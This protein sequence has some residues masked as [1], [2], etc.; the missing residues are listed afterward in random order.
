MKDGETVDG[1]YSGISAELDKIGVDY[2][3][4]VRTTC[5][6]KG[7]YTV[8]H[9]QYED[10][11]ERIAYY[12]G[13]NL[14][15]TWGI[16]SEGDE[17]SGSAYT[18]AEGCWMHEEN[19]VKTRTYYYGNSDEVKRKEYSYTDNRGRIVNLYF[20]NT[21]DGRTIVT[22]MVDGEVIEQYYADGSFEEAEAAAF[23][24]VSLVH[25]PI[26]V[27]PSAL[28]GEVIKFSGAATGLLDNENFSAVLADNVID[29]VA[30]NSSYVGVAY[31]N[32]CNLVTLSSSASESFG[33]L[34]GKFEGIKDGNAMYYEIRRSQLI[35][36][37][38]IDTKMSDL[39]SEFAA[40]V[41]KVYIA[42]HGNVDAFDS[43]EDTC[44]EITI[45][46]EAYT[47][48]NNVPIEFHSYADFLEHSNKI[49][50]SNDNNPNNSSF[51]DILLYDTQNANVLA[52]SS[53]VKTTGRVNGA[54]T[55]FTNEVH[56]T[57]STSGVDFSFFDLNGLKNKIKF[58]EGDEITLD[59]LFGAILDEK[60]F[61]IEVSGEYHY[62]TDKSTVETY[63]ESLSKINE[64]QISKSFV[65]LKGTGTFELSA[66]KVKFSGEVTFDLMDVNYKYLN[67]TDYSSINNVELDLKL[68]DL[69][70]KGE[71]EYALPVGKIIDEFGGAIKKGLKADYDRLGVMKE[72]FRDIDW[73]SFFTTEPEMFY[74]PETER[75]E[76]KESDESPVTCSFEWWVKAFNLTAKIG[77]D[78]WIFD[79]NAE[80][81]L[82]WGASGKFETGEDYTRRGTD[83]DG[84]LSLLNGKVGWIVDGKVELSVRSSDIYHNDFEKAHMK[85]GYPD[86]DLMEYCHSKGLI[87]D[88]QYDYAKSVIA[89]HEAVDK[90]KADYQALA[91]ELDKQYPLG[92]DGITRPPEYYAALAEAE[93]N[94]DRWLEIME[95]QI[96]QAGLD[97]YK[98]DNLLLPGEY[99]PI[100]ERNNSKLAELHWSSEEPRFYGSEAEQLEGGSN[101]NNHPTDGQG[102]VIPSNETP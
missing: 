65:D 8:Y 81:A 63:D 6:K 53:I 96:E 64:E 16:D 91:K 2:G 17:I 84:Y 32:I 83:Y 67:Y 90:L 75:Y 58:K 11:S 69:G 1:I 27:G 98:N 14:Q 15:W 21:E 45:T 99:D 55:V 38:P 77:L 35:N 78:V 70:I 93:E 34:K 37:E 79:L 59:K 85:Y 62:F 39:K 43:L 72:A 88:N 50:A 57:I 71:M 95:I 13:K 94:N 56:D 29:A 18:F 26:P 33:K 36:G 102:V 31:L 42:D 73:K 24:R 86:E 3:K 28:A 22:V 12:Y 92:D 68:L 47:D 41:D 19:G 76:E 51:G 60:S 87:S 5:E 30:Y 100:T 48:Q 49:K 52:D 4:P 20:D 97:F 10:G 46:D 44:T 23:D 9:I 80:V 74:N 7:Q 89:Y 101:P 40:I 61:K 82:S 66:S 25:K 54:I